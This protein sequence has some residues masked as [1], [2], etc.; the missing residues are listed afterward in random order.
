MPAVKS[1]ELGWAQ[2]YM[3][4]RYH[5]MSPASRHD[6]HIV[7]H[8]PLPPGV[9]LAGVRK[10]LNYLVRR[11]EGMRTVYDAGAAPGPLQRVLPPAPVELRIVTTEQDGSVTPAQAVAE[12]TVP[13]FDMAHERPFRVCLLTVG[14]EPRTLVT[15]FSH[16]AFDNRSLE[17]FRSEFEETLTAAVTG[18]PA[19]LPPVSH[20]PVDLAARES[21]RPAAARAASLEHWESELRQLP[22]DMFARRR[23]RTPGVTASWSAS[24]TSPAISD[25]VRDLVR[26]H[27]VWSSEV[28]LAAYTM[29]MAAYCD[30]PVVA[31]QRFVSQRE[32]S[33]HPS[34]LTCM[35]SPSPLRVD[36]SGDPAFGELLQRV[37]EAIEA[38]RPHGYVPYDEIVEASAR[39]S[40]RRGQLVRAGSL[41]PASEVNFLTD[42]SR[43]C[44]VNRARF[45]WNP[46]PVAWSGS[47]TD[48]YLRCQ[49]W[50]DGTTLT[51]R[52]LDAVM[53]RDAVRRFIEGYAW[54]LETQRDPSA[55]VRV[56][57]VARRAAFAPAAS[58]R[59]VRVGQ[60]LADCAET[61]AVLTG[62]PAVR[63]AR[64]VPAAESG[65]GAGGGLVAEITA[66]EPVPPAALRAHVL[67][68]LLT[69]PG[70]RCP[71]V[72]R[73]AVPSPPAVGSPAGG[74]TGGQAATRLLLD[75]VARVN[76]LTAPAASESYVTAGGRV[77][78]IPR[79]L[80]ELRAAGW[81]G[82]SFD[83][84]CGATPLAAVAG[85]LTPRPAAAAGRPGASGP[86][87]AAPA[88]RVAGR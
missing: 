55:D 6:T 51:L 62:H 50:Q 22:A 67:A 20:Q 47:G 18:R 33:G 52:A 17:L 23:T 36:V 68:A 32:P 34:L 28:H 7:S 38:S 88:G 61:E 11:H 57:D 60:D 58:R 59:L 54:L 85:R 10:V 69:R 64:V 35:F 3:W 42:H 82:V 24:L 44:G 39:E 84:L 8:H 48:T 74:P 5:R 49:E 56:T 86:A 43:S 65:S 21:G 9:S 75:L 19:A 1:A 45:A 79:L 71:D 76:G 80:G 70:V 37:S 53:D 26:R 13:D 27:H 30:E 72:F 41:T 78:R 83:D 31:V 2:R 40:F 77:L 12:L 66:H 81:D 4:L 73:I 63:S 15:A 16:V 87:D 46:Q 14:G 25:A 29:L